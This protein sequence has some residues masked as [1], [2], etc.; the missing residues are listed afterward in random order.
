[1]RTT[2]LVLAGALVGI[3]AASLI[4]PP[5]LAWYT[6]PGGLPR[7]A[8]IQA[9]VQ[10]SEVIRY[11]TSRLIR[12]QLIGAAVGAVIGLVVRDC[13]RRPFAAAA[14]DLGTAVL[15]RADDGRLDTLRTYAGPG[16]FSLRRGGRRDVY[17]RPS[18]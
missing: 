10:I 14:D 17:G 2:C 12:G 8:E 11:S 3:V 18:A 9:I 13:P 4:V 5:A 1:M 7:G 15:V 6:T 16:K